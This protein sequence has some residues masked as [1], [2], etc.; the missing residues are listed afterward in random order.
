MSVRARRRSLIEIFSSAT[1]ERVVNDMDELREELRVRCCN[2]IGHHLGVGMRGRSDGAGLQLGVWDAT[3]PKA[4]QLN[5]AEGETRRSL[6][7]HL[8]MQLTAA[9]AAAADRGVKRGAS[10][11]A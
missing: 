5:A 11:R 9:C 7:R 6:A 3:A 1:S 2:E 4:P 8:S 10:L